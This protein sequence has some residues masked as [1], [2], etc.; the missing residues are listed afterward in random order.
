MHGYNSY[1]SITLPPLSII[2][3]K[4]EV[5]NKGGKVYEIN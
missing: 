1:I 4:R 3:L 5:K 2:C